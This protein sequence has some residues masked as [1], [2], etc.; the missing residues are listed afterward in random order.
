MA[1]HYYTKEQEELEK[2]LREKQGLDSY[3]TAK[4]QLTAVEQLKPAYAESQKQQ[5][6]WQQL[7]QK[8]TQRPQSYTPSQQVTD[9]QQQLQQLQQPGAY[10]NNYQTQIRGILDT[11]NNRPTFNYNPG[12]D[13]NY[14]VYRD[15]FMRLGERASED[16]QAQAAALTGGYGSSYGASAGQQAY[17]GYMASLNDQLPT[18]MQLAEQRYQ[19]EI[20]NDYNKLAALQGQ[21]QIEYGKHRD[22]VG[23]YQ[24]NRDYLTNRYDT[25]YSKDYG[26]HRDNVADFESELNYLFQK[27]GALTD[28]NSNLY[29]AEL[30]RWLNDRDYY[31][32]KMGMVPMETGGSGGG[33]R[34]TKS[35]AI[36]EMNSNGSYR[37]YNALPT[38]P[39]VEQQ[40][41]NN[42]MTAITNALESGLLSDEEEEML[43]E[44]VDE[45]TKNKTGYKRIAGI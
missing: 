20:A 42:M 38:S 45:D 36:V 30:E 11:I 44:I 39:A 17:Q 6:A 34:S 3:G 32:Q 26:Q 14:K 1:N 24:T 12:E 13:Q 9:A 16:V 18:L 40:T 15:Q 5:E 43:I 8:E 35:N 31:L 33:G 7:T 2:V 28:E 27:Y 23:D 29:M 37:T 41:R 22:E 4:Q 10:Q 21:E 25:E 19:N